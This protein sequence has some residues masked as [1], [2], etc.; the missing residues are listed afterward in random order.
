MVVALFD[1]TSSSYQIIV[2]SV[3]PMMRCAVGAHLDVGLSEW[4]TVQIRWNSAC[5]PSL[6]R[7]KVIFC[8]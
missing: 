1:N 2:H 7:G 8:D 5:I 4:S 6:V 3:W